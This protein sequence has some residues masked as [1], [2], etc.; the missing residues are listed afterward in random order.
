MA[1]SYRHQGDI[2][3]KTEEDCRITGLTPLDP[4]RLIFTDFINKSIKLVDTRSGS[5]TD[6][7]TRVVLP[8]TWGI[9]KVN[10]D[11]L[12][13]TL[14]YILYEKT[15]QFILASSDRLIKKHAWTSNE[16][17]YGISYYENK[18]ISQQNS[19]NL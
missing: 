16:E 3:V 11:Q 13:V 7:S 4:D 17:C 18:I 1:K 14:P 12:A 5:F 2:F 6:W 9:I 8:V 15:T 19:P 10:E